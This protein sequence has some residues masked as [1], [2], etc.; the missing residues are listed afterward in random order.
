M[1]MLSERGAS[2]RRESVWESGGHHMTYL[3]K[4]STADPHW[5]ILTPP[6]PGRWRSSPSP[7]TQEERAG[8]RRPVLFNSPHPT[9]SSRG[10]GENFRWLYQ[11]APD[12][13]HGGH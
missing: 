6:P 11:D 5:P 1:D 7:P 12:P 4:D 3:S 9:R 8:E 13:R 10:E 2:V